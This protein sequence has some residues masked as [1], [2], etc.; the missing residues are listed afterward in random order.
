MAGQSDGWITTARV[1]RRAGFGVAGQQ[2][3][4]VAGQ[5]W[6]RYVDAALAADPDADPG[7]VATPMPTLP[8][9]RGPGKGASV[10]DRKEFNQQIFGQMT[11]LSQWWLRRMTAVQQPIHEKLTLLWHNHF[12]TSAEKVRVAAHMAAQNQKLR[13]LSLGDF[14]KLAYAMLTDAAMLRW[15][16][17]QTNTA[18]APNENLAREFM[19]LFT[20]G[21]GDGYTEDDVREGARALT[22]W[23]IRPGGEP[24]MVPKRHDHTAKTIFGVTRNFDAEGFC[25]LV[26]AQPKSPQYVAGRL[27]QQLASDTPP[28]PQALDRLVTAYGPGRNLGALTRAILTD[29]EFIG[30]RAAIVNTP[31]EWLVGVIRTLRVP[32]DTPARLKMADAALKSLGQRPF[33][34]PDVGG[35]PHG[36]V[37][38]STASAD[39]RMRAASQMAR[40]GDLST[41]EDTGAG[42]RIDAVGY[43]IGVGAWSDR[44]VTALQPLVRTPVQLVAAAVN[45]PEYLTS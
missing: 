39:V 45:T 17:A 33:Y 31:V 12:A 15:L 9:L 40:N 19:E 4:A 35:W 28:S 24:T 5:D 26:L 23:V 14:H 29:D 43:L 7:A 10:A 32:V 41:V 13:S 37:W 27:W 21:H 36:R 2:V 30:S 22:G 34:P 18:K 3:D 8:T 16:D 6:S 20:L 11:E 42:D 25:G 44:T 1:L 38:M